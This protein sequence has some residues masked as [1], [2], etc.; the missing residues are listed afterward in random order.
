MNLLMWLVNLMIIG[1]QIKIKL[2][3]IFDFGHVPVIIFY[4]I[5][6]DSSCMIYIVDW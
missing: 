4:F 1:L 2:K 5:I 6:F 3:L